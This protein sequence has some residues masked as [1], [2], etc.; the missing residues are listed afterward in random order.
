MSI[1]NSCYN[2]FPEF[3]TYC[4]YVLYTDYNYKGDSNGTISHFLPGTSI[5]FN[6]MLVGFDPNTVTVTDQNNNDT[7]I[8]V[9]FMN[10][11]NICM[12]G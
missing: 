10:V 6:K 2:R 12:I 11:V 8:Y 7:Y 5:I 3:L 9:I 1:T 4:L